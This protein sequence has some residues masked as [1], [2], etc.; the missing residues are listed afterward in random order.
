MATIAT[1]LNVIKVE[2][3][4]FIVLYVIYKLKDNR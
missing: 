4:I 2:H 1:L 3:Y